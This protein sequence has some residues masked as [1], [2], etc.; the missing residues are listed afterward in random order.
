MTDWRTAIRKAA[1]RGD[2]DQLAND[3]AEAMRRVVL[4][5]VS[6]E[7]RK[8]AAT[9]WMRH[10]VL[11]AASVVAILSLGVGAGLRFD[12]ATPLPAGETMSSDESA[13]ADAAGSA[14]AIPVSRQLQ[15]MTAGGTRI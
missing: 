10:P 9:L 2:Q 5:A 1:E 11:V 7:A 13:K 15:F 3:D 14:G 4:S 12:A 8:P 6:G